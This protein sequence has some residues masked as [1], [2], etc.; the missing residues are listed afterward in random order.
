MQEYCYR[1][2]QKAAWNSLKRSKHKNLNQGRRTKV[3]Q[4]ILDD[5]DPLTSRHSIHG[6]NFKR[7]N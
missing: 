3:M 1:F 5:A 6:R 4:W 7:K 2:A